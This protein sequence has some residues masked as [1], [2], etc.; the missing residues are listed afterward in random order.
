MRDSV[1]IN[2]RQ[3]VCV[4]GST[5]SIG[6]NTLD[7]LARHPAQ[8]EVWALTGASRVDELWALCLQWRPAFA[9]MPDEACAARLRA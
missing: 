8:F 3:R 5:G 7:V 1:N 9:V 6:A 2:H 4:L